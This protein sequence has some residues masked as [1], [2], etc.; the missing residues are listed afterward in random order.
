MKVS[1]GTVRSFFPKRKKNKVSH[2]SVP[3]KEGV[4]ASGEIKKTAQARG[5][6]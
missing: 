5:E 6:L 1:E 3:R 2:P 4:L